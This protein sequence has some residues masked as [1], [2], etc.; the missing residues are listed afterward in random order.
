MTYPKQRLEAGSERCL[1]KQLAPGLIQILKDIADSDTDPGDNTEAEELMRDA[2]KARATDV[3]LD[4]YG[5]RYRVRFRIDDAMCDVADLEGYEGKRLLNQVRALALLDPVPTFKPEG[6]RF[7][8]QLDE[9][10]LDVRVTDAPCFAGDKLAIRILSPVGTLEDARDLGLDDAKVRYLQEWLE[11]VG[12]MMLIVGPTGSGKT[13]TLYSLLHQLKLVSNHVV[14][15][16]DPVEYEIPG[17]NQIPVQEERGLTFVAGA[18]LMLR[19]DPDYLVIGEITEGDSAQAALNAAASGK[20]SMG[21]LHSRDAADTV[22]VL[23]NFGLDDFEVASNVELVVAQRLVRRLCPS[24]RE[25]RPPSETDC[26]WLKSQQIEPPSLMWMPQGCSE[27][28]DLGY[29]GR[30]GIFEIWRPDEEDYAFILNN[31]DSHTIRRHLA[32]RGH[33]FL[34]DDGMEKALRG[35]IC[36]S[37]LRRLG[38]LGSARSCHSADSQKRS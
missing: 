28:N 30:I 32:E 29:K 18:Q 34:I 4:P 37:E 21:T 10:K 20:A 14:T 22:M 7:T 23:R 19:L 36:I 2:I 9:R 35:D 33:K 38:A 27:C 6:G 1:K 11:T 12:G 16:E 24:C 15:L 8:Y 13:T 5:D 26:N 31:R 17:V 25:Q 3:H